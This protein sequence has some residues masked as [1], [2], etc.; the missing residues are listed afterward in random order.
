MGSVA[1]RRGRFRTWTQLGL[2]HDALTDEL[3]E[4]DE[5]QKI[6][7][8][9]PLF[10]CRAIGFLT[11]TLTDGPSPCARV[12]SSDASM[13]LSSRYSHKSHNIPKL[14]LPAYTATGHVSLHL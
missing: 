9:D 2:N 13:V 12:T 14:T 10:Y 1:S 6:H 3:L 5:C 4:T 7:R 11:N 8:R